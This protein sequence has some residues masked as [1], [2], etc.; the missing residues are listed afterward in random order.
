[1]G[2]QHAASGKT[3]IHHDGALGD[4]LLS[5]PCIGAIRAGAGH[6]HLAGRPDAARL[7]KEAGYA[8]E[9]SSADSA[10]YSPLYAGVADEKA[11]GFLARFDRAFLFTVRGDSLLAASLGELVPR[12]RTI[13]TVPPPGVRTHV[14]EFRFGQMAEGGGGEC[15][16]PVLKAPPAS[17]ERAEALLAGAGYDGRA[18]R[19]IALHPGSG[20]RGKCWPLESFCALAERLHREQD[21]FI[22]FLAG[23]A[24]DAEQ[25]EG[26]RRFVGG[27][28]RSLFVAAE[29]LP[30]VAALLSLSALFIGNDSGIAHLAAATGRACLSLFG[31][32]DPLLWRP[33]G[34]RIRV[35]D[36]GYPR[37]SLSSLSVDEVYAQAAAVLAHEKG[38]H[39]SA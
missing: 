37:A 26:I 17:R 11:R 23:P 21:V 16:C 36:A 13:I 39:N 9:V 25:K 18:T 8:D 15:P 24:E 30:V 1:M 31:A 10:L 32:T 29:E 5:L 2:E 7:L 4:L 28:G 3:F 12:T 33:L 27:A 19:L 22:L 34:R 14:A 6:V 35:V 20:G 38:I